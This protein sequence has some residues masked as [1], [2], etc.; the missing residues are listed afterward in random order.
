MGIG[1]LI[2]LTIHFI[3]QSTINKILKNNINSNIGMESLYLIQYESKPV[4]E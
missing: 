2:F 1:T 3:I 4:I